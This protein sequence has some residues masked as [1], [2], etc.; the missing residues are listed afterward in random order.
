MSYYRKFIP[1]FAELAKPLM[2]LSSLHPTQF[3]WL[4]IHQQSF[5]NMIRAIEINTSLNL[6]DPQKP[7]FVQT[8]ASDVAG[9][10][11]VF[12]K[13]DQ[14]NELLMACV[15]RTFTKAERK[16]GTFRKEVLALLYCLKSM[17][18]F[19]RF[20][21]KLVILIDAKSI[22]FLRLCKES[23]GI[24]LR[25][26]LELSK[27]EAE[28]HHVP[29]VEN[30]VSDVLSRNHKNIDDIVKESKEKNI[31]SEKQTEQILARLTIPQGKRFSSEEVRN[32]LELESLPAP[33]PKTKRKSE[34]KAKLGKRI[35]K[36]LRPHLARKKLNCHLLLFVDQV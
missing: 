23:Q 15:S 14:G 24:L 3:K 11:R 35:I 12:Q 30:E 19:L 25:F 9:A 10:G 31:L 28:I 18:F 16:Y 20:A 7:F 21:N 17:D 34:S 6:P 26:S 5:D 36:K 32:L 1:K 2:D 22:L 27:Y 4:P 29:G 33:S 8:D 13:D